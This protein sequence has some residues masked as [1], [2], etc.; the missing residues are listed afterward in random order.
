[1]RSESSESFTRDRIYGVPTYC[2]KMV[3]NILYTVS[4]SQVGLKCCWCRTILQ[5]SRSLLCLPGSLNQSIRPK[6]WQ[7]P[8][9]SKET[10]EQLHDMFTIY[11]MLDPRTFP[12]GSI[13][14]LAGRIRIAMS[15]SHIL[16]LDWEVSD[17]TVNDCFS[18]NRFLSIT[19]H[20]NDLQV[21][22]KVN[23]NPKG[24]PQPF[25]PLGV[26]QTL[27]F[28]ISFFSENETHWDNYPCLSWIHSSRPRN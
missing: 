1:M 22:G 20:H 3:P 9:C 10:Y 5:A 23:M 17:W 12:A 7:R 15:T 16:Q 27:I 18:W 26:W 2:K 6:I 14:I 4:W 24:L 21:P 8:T 11:F 28:K 13:Y 19:R 25:H